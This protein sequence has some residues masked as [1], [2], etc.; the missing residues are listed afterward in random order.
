MSYMVW[1]GSSRVRRW[2]AKEGIG[3]IRCHAWHVMEKNK[4]RCHAWHVK[5][6]VG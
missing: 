5:E 3:A 4:M 6:R 1:G 2:H